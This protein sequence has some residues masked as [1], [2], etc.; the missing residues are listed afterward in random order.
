[1]A[2]IGADEMGLGA[3]VP[4]IGRDRFAGFGIAAGNDDLRAFTGKS[5]CGGAA[6]PGEGAGDEDD[7][8]CH[9][10]DS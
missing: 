5:F 6:D 9:S 4:Q 2:D 8:C 7:G 1:M 10:S 3:E